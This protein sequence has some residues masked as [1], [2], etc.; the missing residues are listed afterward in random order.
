VVLKALSKNP[1]ERYVSVQ[2]FAQALERASETRTGTL[3]HDPEV[4]G[5]LKVISPV[6]PGTPNQIFLSSSHADNDFALRLQTDLQRRGI[7]VCNEPQDSTRDKFERENTLRQAIRATDVVVLVV[8]SQ[9]RTSHIVKEHL[10]IAALYQRRLVSVWVEG[11]EMTGPF[12]ETGKETAS[13]DVIDARELRYQIALDELVACLDKETVTST[14]AE[15]L[16]TKEVSDPRNPYKGLRAFA[17]GDTGDFFGR[18]GLIAE[19]VDGVKERLRSEQPGTSPARLLAVI[20]PSGSG[21]SSVV[22][23]GLLPRLRLGALSGSQE[24]IYLSPM[25]PGVHPLEALAL[26]L[27]PHLPDRSLKSIREDLEDDSARGLHLLASHL[28]KG[29]EKKVVL[30]VDQFEEVFHLT[31][32]ED[33]RERFCDLLLTAITE[34]KGQVLV[35]LTFRADFYDH[36]MTAYGLGRLI[37]QHQS[38][39]W[40][41]E[42]DELRAA[43]KGPVGLPDVNL[44]FEGN[45]VGD[46]LYEVRGQVGALPLLQFT[47]DQ[48]FERRKDHLLTQRAYQEIG[49]VKGALSKHA[50]KT[51]LALPKDSHREVAR[52]LFLRLIEPGVTEQDTTRRRA[53]LTETILVDSAQ[54]RLMQ[55]TMEHFV[56]ARLLTTNA[57]E[58]MET[59]IE[60]SHEALIR[61]WLRLV[62]WLRTARDDIRLQHVISEDAVAWELYKCPGDRLYRGSQLKEAQVWAKRN[63]ASQQ[64]HTF[65]QASAARQLRTFITLRVVAVLML[66]FAGVAGWLAFYQSQLPKSDYVTNTNDSGTGSLPSAI[67][68]ASNGD[69]I[70]FSPNM[71]GKTIVLK[72]VN[73]DISQKNLTIEGPATDPITIHEVGASLVVSP[74]AS[75]TIAGLIFQ[76]DKNLNSLIW[77]D[78]IL[79]LK[80]C[81][82]SGNT[83]SNGSGI[84]NNGTLTMTNSIVSGNIASNGCGGIVNQGT[85][86]MMSSRVLKNT[87]SGSDGGGI[88]NNGTLTMT[89]SIVS[90]NTASNGFGG[91]INNYAARLTMTN[92]AVSGNT[93]LHGGGIS[94]IGGMLT[95]TSSTVSDNTASNGGGISN[96]DGTL[97]MTNSTVSGNT[98]SHVGGIYTKNDTNRTDTNTIFTFCTIVNN[99]ASDSDGFDVATVAKLNSQGI[100]APFPHVEI[101]ASIV[102]T[103]GA[104]GSPIAGG[105]ITSEGHLVITPMSARVIT[106]DGYN[107]IQHMSSVAFAS[108][109]PDVTD[110]SVDDLTDVFGAHP[111]LQENGGPTL[112]FAL[113]QDSQNPALNMIPPSVCQMKEIY[114]TKLHLYT[115]ERG[116]VRPGKEM[117][118]CDS[119]AYESQG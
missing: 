117:Q 55:E 60:V 95:M 105:V 2:S 88:W 37:E 36:L 17:E 16:S 24:W 81:T 48:L 96:I 12:P 97:T 40:P 33:E 10:R 67:A 57:R 89:N 87:D 8:S 43:I 73:V 119:G 71:Y 45:L 35:M 41:M 6:P 68:S 100:L 93:A 94:N 3:R 31:T 30:F 106:S 28:V 38:V 70:D 62:E 86:T 47:L 21:K 63:T 102:S 107:V 61:E 54:T 22:M 109:A 104:Q 4:T 112:T 108:G 82:L 99:S 23:A 14:S 9:T 69:T 25:V 85:L 78:G 79:S 26:T 7:T 77:N 15:S 20:G 75:V 52:T 92:S 83:A 111:Q 44:A 46:L 66:A 27:A 90:G 101:K 74:E 80:N 29:T 113:L 34:P 19:L 91:G 84:W 56:Q 11:E 114:D 64:E 76:G 49:G 110:R 53:T 39:I 65:L 115:D 98:A 18:D 58:G 72:N 1:K 32:S 13:N 103:N 116:M 118:R 42:V 50:E 59:T 51:Y 5:R